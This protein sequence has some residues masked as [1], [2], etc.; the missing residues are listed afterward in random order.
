MA[1][2]EAQHAAAA[3]ARTGRIQKDRRPGFNT[4]WATNARVQPA[5]RSRSTRCGLRKVAPPG[6]R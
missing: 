3:T 6:V 4:P 2:E 1:R 5:L